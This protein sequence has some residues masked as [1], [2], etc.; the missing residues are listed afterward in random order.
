[1]PFPSQTR[2]LGDLP[3]LN[4]LAVHTT[5]P[6]LS[7]AITRGGRTLAETTLPPA[8][9][10]LENLAPAIKDLTDELPLDLHD[11]DGFAVARGP[12]SFSGIRAGIATIKGM[13]L[14]L[15]KPVVGIGSLEI[16]AW[17]AAELGDRVA[18]IIDARRGEVYTAIYEK[19]GAGLEC[20]HGPA[21]IKM[22]S[23]VSLAGN[24][25]GLL[26]ICGD[27]VADP[28]VESHSRLVRSPVTVPSAS[29]CAARAAD[30]L[31]EGRVDS[32]HALAPLYIRRS[33]AEEKRMAAIE[34]PK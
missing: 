25:E 12:G 23:L 1:M 10:H 18:P 2:Q 17:Q 4:I 30:R 6:R 24:F 9:K 33:D 14:A 32:L 22:D 20:C 16:L 7:V 31:R 13:A 5:T 3:N 15:G 26:T 19:T 8:R 29:A 11:I 21:L 34:S 27:T 28:I